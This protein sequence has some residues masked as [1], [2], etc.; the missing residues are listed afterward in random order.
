VH[1]T[2]EQALTDVDDSARGLRNVVSPL[3]MVY[4]YITGLGALHPD[5]D[6]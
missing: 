2:W 1:P 4:F 3:G 6:D 5:T